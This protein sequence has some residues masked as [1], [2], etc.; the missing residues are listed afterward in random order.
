MEHK[1]NVWALDD[2]GLH[3]AKVAALNK[4][5]EC[6]KLLDNIGIQLTAVNPDFVR[7]QQAKS[8]KELEKRLKEGQKKMVKKYSKSAPR[9]KA[10]KGKKIALSEVNF[11]LQRPDEANNSENEEEQA[12]D[13]DELGELVDISGPTTSRT[14]PKTASGAMLNTFSALAKKPMHIEYYT[15]DLVAS[16]S[17]PILVHQ[18]VHNKHKALTELVPIVSEFEIE[19]DSPLATMLHSIDVYDEA[20]VLLREKMDFETLSDCSEEDL[21]SVGLH[22]GPI[23]KIRSAIIRRNEVLRNPGPMLDSDL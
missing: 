20:Q 22:L 6:C 15:D 4:R 9:I 18:R 1:A 13:D 5:L 21:K 10:K 2:R 19:N 7:Q 8:L 16:N 12:D 23:K 17:D 3:P 14:L 11:V